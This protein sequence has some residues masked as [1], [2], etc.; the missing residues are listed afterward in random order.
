M[1]SY[2]PDDEPQNTTFCCPSQPTPGRFFGNPW[3]AHLQRVREPRPESRRAIA[4]A[5]G[6]SSVNRRQ[7]PRPPGRSLARSQVASEPLT[8]ETLRQM[9]AGSGTSITRFAIHRD[10]RDRHSR[11]DERMRH[12]PRSVGP[13]PGSWSVPPAF[14]RGTVSAARPHLPVADLGGG[15]G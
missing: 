5:A 12:N 6:N 10:D 9:R 4:V 8:W 2:G 11:Q 3:E 1:A 7:R 13:G 14:R 15:A